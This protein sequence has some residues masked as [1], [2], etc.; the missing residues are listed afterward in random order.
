[1]KCVASNNKLSK[2]IRKQ[3]TD[4]NVHTLLVSFASVLTDKYGYGKK[5]T[6]QILTSVFDRADSIVKG[7]CKIEELEAVLK[8]E[9]D[10]IFVPGE[11]PNGRNTK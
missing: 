2:E 6:M 8:E 1:M 3:T 9:Y 5:K 10:I 11:R 7:Y 4:T